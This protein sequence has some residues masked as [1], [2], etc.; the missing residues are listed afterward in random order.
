VL[1]GYKFFTHV[2]TRP[3]KN[4]GKNEKNLISVLKTPFLEPKEL[5]FFQTP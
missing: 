3:F 5:Q 1:D 2:I 4:Q